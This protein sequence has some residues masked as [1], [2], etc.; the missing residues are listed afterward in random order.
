M[1][2]TTSLIIF[3]AGLLGLV[4]GSFINVITLRYRPDSKQKLI[5]AISGRSHCPYCKKQL[6]GLKLIPI[7]S[8]FALGF[9]CRE[10]RVKISWQYPMVEFLT[11]AVFVGITAKILS[12]NFFEYYFISFPKLRI[13][14]FVIVLFWLFFS[15]ILI[16]LSIIDFKHYLIP[17]KILFPGIIGAILLN[18]S[19]LFFNGFS[20]TDF[21]LTKGLNFLGPVSN[22][23]L[24]L[25]TVWLNYLLGAVIFSGF[26]FLIYFFSRGKG[27]GFG[28]VKLGIFLGLIL[29]LS[30]SI[31]ALALAF[32]IGAGISIV[33]LYLKKKK[34]KE[35]IPFGPFLVLGS[36]IAVIFGEQIVN[37]YLRLAMF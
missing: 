22:L 31:L 8:F 32:I 27:M 37:L 12:L 3:F 29:G 21:F 9:R 23:L 16:I 11:G 30:A 18:I 35:Q 33:V 36:L 10:C 34:L 2:T 25:E 14:I 20:K 24:P 28:D 4:V 5:K 26:L 7:I 17:D 19:F 13:I 1:G 15:T 6:T